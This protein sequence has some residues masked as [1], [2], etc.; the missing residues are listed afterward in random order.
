MTDRERDRDT[1][2][3]SSSLGSQKEPNAGLDPGTPESHPE[4]KADT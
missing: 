2:R 1:G 4:P 3:G